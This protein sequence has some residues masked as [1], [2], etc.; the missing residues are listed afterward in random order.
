MTRSDRISIRL[1]PDHKAAFERAAEK[2]AR[3]VS[4]LAEIVLVEWLRARGLLPPK[5]DDGAGP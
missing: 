1:R 3:T 4:A 2:D 5:D